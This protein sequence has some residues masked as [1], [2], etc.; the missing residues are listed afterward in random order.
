MFPE[1]EAF[2][3]QCRDVEQLLAGLDPHDWTRPT[4]CPPLSVREVVAHMA[5]VFHDTAAHLG[6]GVEEPASW[7]RVSW[8]DY[9]SDVG[10]RV[11]RHSRS[12]AEAHPDD[13]E[14]RAWWREGVAAVVQAA[15]AVDAN[16]VVRPSKPVRAADLV[17]TRVLESAVHGMDVGHATLR[18]ERVAL[19][20]SRVVIEILET[21]LGAK[22]P[23]QMGWTTQTF[24][25]TGLGRRPLNPAERWTLGPLA[26]RF[27]LI[28]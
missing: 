17:A 9:D 5:D 11:V 24:I 22:L 20:A 13:D 16:L 6:E 27:P 12:A 18:G 3:V 4:R 28:T 21:R 19:E 7:D 10:E 1:I 26:E 8:W 14:L 15:M 23:P 25:L 2:E